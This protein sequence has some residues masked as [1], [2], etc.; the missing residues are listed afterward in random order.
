MGVVSLY[1]VLIFWGEGEQGGG[2]FVHTCI[3]VKSL[4]PGG[5]QRHAHLPGDAPHALVRPDLITVWRVVWRV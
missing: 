2:N 3:H 5:L 4:L 1:P